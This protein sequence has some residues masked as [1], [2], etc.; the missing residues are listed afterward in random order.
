MAQ[1]RV[2]THSK[3]VT[4]RL[5]EKELTLM[6]KYCAEN[7]LTGSEYLRTL[8]RIHLGIAEDMRIVANLKPRPKE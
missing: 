2:S 7:D 3:H 5:T 8:L 4:V 6:E 1:P